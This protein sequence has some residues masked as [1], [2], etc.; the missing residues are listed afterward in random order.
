MLAFP[1][2][3][4]IRFVTEYSHIAATNEIRDITQILL[5]RNPTRRI[6]RRVQKDSAR[7]R[8]GVEKSSMSET[9]GRNSVS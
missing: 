7:R 4:A 1:D 5:G 3:M 8:I 9:C 6:V 2:H